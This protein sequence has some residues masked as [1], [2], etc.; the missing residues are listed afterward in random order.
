MKYQ[1]PEVHRIEHEQSNRIS[2]LKR[3]GYTNKV[4]VWALGLILYQLIEAEYPFDVLW[5][6]D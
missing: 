2:I 5:K 1:A 6:L 4:D 3:E